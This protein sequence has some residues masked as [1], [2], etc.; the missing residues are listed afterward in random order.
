MLSLVRAHVRTLVRNGQITERGLAARVR[1]SQTYL[2]RALK[3]TRAMTPDLA[4]R[5]LYELETSLIDL[6]ACNEA[7]LAVK[8]V[9]PGSKP[10][11]AAAQGKRKA[12]R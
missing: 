10:G 11:P 6:V 3:G 2:H 12:S 9:G 1:V 7:A 8:R 5:L 4:D